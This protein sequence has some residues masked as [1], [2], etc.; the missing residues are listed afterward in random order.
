MGVLIKLQGFQGHFNMS[1][2][3]QV[4]FQGF[5][6]GYSERAQKALQNIEEISGVFHGT[7]E[8]FRWGGH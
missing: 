1:W 7:S 4:G 5:Q 6:V 3:F 8:T 2:G